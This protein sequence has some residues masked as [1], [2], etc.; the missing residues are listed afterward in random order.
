MTV[1]YYT[2]KLLKKHVL[3]RKNKDI[4]TFSKVRHF[5]HEKIKIIRKP[6]K[7][8]KRK[9][10]EMLTYAPLKSLVFTFDLKIEI[11]GLVLLKLRMDPDPTGD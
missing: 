8:N 2:K 1:G 3:K 7:D 9:T 10:L 6:I 5:I 4:R 11:Q